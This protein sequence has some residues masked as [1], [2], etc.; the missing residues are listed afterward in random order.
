MK[1]ASRGRT[2]P[3]TCRSRLTSSS[4]H[5]WSSSEG[6][7]SNCAVA[8]N[9]CLLDGW[10]TSCVFV[11]WQLDSGLTELTEW[12]AVALGRHNEQWTAVTTWQVVALIALSGA[13]LGCGLLI[14]RACRDLARC[15]LG[16][17]P[18]WLTDAALFCL[19]QA[20][21]LGPLRD[22]RSWRVLYL[23][24]QIIGR[25]RARPIVA[26]A[27]LAVV[28]ALPFVCAKA[29]LE[30][31]PVPLLGFALPAFPPP[32]CS[33]SWSSL[34]HCSGSLHPGIETVRLV[35][36]S[37]RRAPRGPG[38]SPLFTTPC[39]PRHTSIKRPGSL[40]MLLFGGGLAAGAVTLVV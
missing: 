4:C 30:Q 19:H 34:A 29:F 12:A 25:V 28:L 14:Y 26:A 40:S 33:V 18:D 24:R 37:D 9:D 23:E 10:W 16:G 20:R 3:T 11:P 31:Y 27:L 22:R 17:Q 5:C 35:V 7:A 32:P 13:T 36:C 8:L 15:A 2:T 38:S 1:F 39:W 21:R 6:F